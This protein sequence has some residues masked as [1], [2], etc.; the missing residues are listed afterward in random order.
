MREAM[1]KS[2][3][4]NTVVGTETVDACFPLTCSM[5]WDM[6]AADRCGVTAARLSKSDNN[7]DVNNAL[8]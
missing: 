7:S 1:D 5:Y 2:D 6:P 3:G 4:G 8:Q